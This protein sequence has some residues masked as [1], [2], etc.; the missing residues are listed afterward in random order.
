MRDMCGGIWR[1]FEWQGDNEGGEWG[2]CRDELEE[3]VLEMMSEG[4]VFLWQP[5]A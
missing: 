3:K 4:L 1:L 5:S 2:V